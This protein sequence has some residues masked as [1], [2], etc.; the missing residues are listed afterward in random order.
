MAGGFSFWESLRYSLDPVFTI[1]NKFS[2]KRGFNVFKVVYRRHTNFSI[3]AIEQTFNG[4]ADFGKKV[5]CTVSRNGDLIHKTF[6]QVTLP[7]LTASGGEVQWVDKV[8]HQLLNSVELE[9]GGQ[10]IDKHYRDWFN[11]W[12]ELSLPEGL[13]M[14][15]DV[16]VGATS[17]LTTPATSLP[18]KTLYVPLIFWFNLNPGLDRFNDNTGRD[19]RDEKQQSRE[20][21]AKL[22][23]KTSLVA[24]RELPQLLVRSIR[25][26]PS[27][28]WKP[29]KLSLPNRVEDSAMAQN[30]LRYGDNATDIWAISSQASD[31]QK[32]V[33]RSDDGGSVMKYDWSKV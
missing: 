5:T 28:C 7:A 23:D 15:Y 12:N 20:K 14:G 31:S 1:N 17:D 6:L 27:N 21:C 25:A 9:I 4:T 8:G 33:Q 11:I 24:A 13:R 2:E 26:T 19:H 3:E 29:L 16:M 10:S 30:L 18:S 22:A 32:K